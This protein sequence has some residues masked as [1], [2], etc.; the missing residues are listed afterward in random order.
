MA[1]TL[2]EVAPLQ[3]M[4]IGRNEWLFS[5]GEPVVGHDVGVVYLLASNPKY[6]RFKIIDQDGL[7]AYQPMSERPL[8]AD[9]IAHFERLAREQES[10][11]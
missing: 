6:A 8:T 4:S 7:P 5:F 1:K 2:I 10:T 9:E 3:V 11:S